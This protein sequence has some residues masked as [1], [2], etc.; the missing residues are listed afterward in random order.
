MVTDLPLVLYV[1]PRDGHL[2][3]LKA[4]ENYLEGL[5]RQNGVVWEL[6]RVAK[7]Y[8]FE[9]N[10]PRENGA[11]FMLKIRNTRKAAFIP[12]SGDFHYGVFGHTISQLEN[13]IFEF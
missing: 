13:F 10:I 6:S 7:K 11:V 1:V 9:Y 5:R 4:L 8:C 12:F 2:E 3:T